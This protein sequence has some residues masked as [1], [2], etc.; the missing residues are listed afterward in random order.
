MSTEI[1]RLVPE[2]KDPLDD[3]TIRE[4]DIASRKLEVD[5]ASAIKHGVGGK[6]YEGL[7]LV[8]WLWAKR[9]DPQAKLEPFRDVTMPA[10]ATAL[11]MDDDDEEEDDDDENPT[12]RASGS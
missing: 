1:D 5:V 11:G 4:L 10:L 6:R 2:G 9:S 12:A 7:A 3:L 8:A